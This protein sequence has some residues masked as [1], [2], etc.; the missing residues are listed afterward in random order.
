MFPSLSC[1][2]FSYP[3]KEINQLEAHILVS[4]TYDTTEPH[5]ISSYAYEI[6]NHLT[7]AQDFHDKHA[8]RR[9]QRVMAVNRFGDEPAP[10][11]VSISRRI[12]KEVWGES[13]SRS[14]R[15]HPIQYFSQE[16]LPCGIP[17]AVPPSTTTVTCACRCDEA[18]SCEPAC[19]SNL[20]LCCGRVTAHLRDEKKQSADLPLLREHR[21]DAV[22]PPSMP[23]H[24]QAWCADTKPV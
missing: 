23:L 14:R 21:S 3:G 22:T 24:V 4:P 12:I 20:S 15:P 6:A 9:A 10:A 18:L 2:S 1:S 5:G 7:L 17:V 11:I 8:A 16:Y 19:R 13:D